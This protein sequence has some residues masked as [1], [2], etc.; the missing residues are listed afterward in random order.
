MP[1]LVKP[2]TE[3][4]AAWLEAHDEWG[5]GAH[6]DGFGLQPSDDVRSDAGFSAWVEHLVAE[7]GHADAP[8]PRCMYWWIVENGRVLG[9]IALRQGDLELVRR[10]GNVGYGIRPSARGHG[11]AGWALGQVLN[12]A[13]LIG[14]QRILAV[15]ASDNVASARTIKLNG[16]VLETV[17]PTEQGAA[18]RYW[19]EL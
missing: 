6:E 18:R 3:M 19:I 11:L 16:G 2:T 17:E 7:S 13:R 10:A 1:E 8:E 14:M 5:P 4:H 15:C 9:G 12:E